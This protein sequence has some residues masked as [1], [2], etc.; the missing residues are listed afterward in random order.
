MELTT[1]KILKTRAEQERINLDLAARAGQLLESSSVRNLYTHLVRSIA[2]GLDAL[3]DKMEHSHGIPS[4][5]MGQ[6]TSFIDDLRSELHKK[7]VT[8]MDEYMA[9]QESERLSA[10]QED[11]KKQP[12]KPKKTQPRKDQ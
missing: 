3:P 5:T 10:E 1:E 6:L 11:T 2:D 7:L 4:E 8:G 12:Q 9:A